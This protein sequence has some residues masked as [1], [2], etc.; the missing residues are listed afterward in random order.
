LDDSGRIQLPA[1][2]RRHLDEAARISVEIRP[3]GVLLRPEQ[4]EQHDT[5]GL[6]SDM[7]PQDA[8]PEAETDGRSRLRFWR[9]KKGAQ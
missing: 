7:L 5:E 9:R 8:L 6:L 3:E 1:A 2:V 4:V